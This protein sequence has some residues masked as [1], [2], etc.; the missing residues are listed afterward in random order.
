MFSS[1]ILECSSSSLVEEGH[2]PDSGEGSEDGEEDGEE[3][4]DLGE[5]E[6]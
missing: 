5:C 6:G 3:C 2:E 1:Q 4:S